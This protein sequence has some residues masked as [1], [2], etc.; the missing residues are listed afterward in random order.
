MRVTGVPVTCR[1][2]VFIY[3]LDGYDVVALSRVDLDIAAGEAVALVGPSGSGKSTLLSLMAGLLR[4]SAGSLRVGDHDLSRAGDAELQ[5]MRATELG[6][7]LQGDRNLI[8]YLSALDNVRFAQ[9]GVPRARRVPAMDL[10]E[11]VGMSGA[12]ARTPGELTPG[13]RQRLSVAVGAAVGGGLLLADEPTSQLD[14][15]A[16]ESVVAALSAVRDRGSTVV[17][18]THDPGVAA[19]FG[20]SVTIRDGRVGAEGRRGEDFLVVGTDGAVHLPAELLTDMPPG[21]LLRVRRDSG[22]GELR[23]SPAETA[24][25]RPT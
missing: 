18:V 22:S 3:R 11:T 9:R 2:L 1:G 6:V 14:A 7:V 19:R 16:R 24:E 10:L 15:E 21:T 25:V 8:P 13:G 17:V 5:R 20:R 12:A 4:P 23:L